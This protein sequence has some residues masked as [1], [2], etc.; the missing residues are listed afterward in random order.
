MRE[1]QTDTNRCE[2][3]QTDA[4]RCSQMQSDANRYSQIRSDATPILEDK[5][6]RQNTSTII[7]R[8]KF[9][10]INGS[11][12]RPFPLFFGNVS[13]R[14]WLGSCRG[15]IS[16]SSRR[17]AASLSGAP[18][19]S[20][21]SCVSVSGAF[22]VSGIDR[23]RRIKLVENVADHRVNAS[24][25]LLGQQDRSAETSRN[26]KEEEEGG[27]GGRGR[28]RKRREEV[29]GGWRRGEIRR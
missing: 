2:Q 23:F 5:W 10:F 13:E 27:G 22:G 4:N 9:V 19:V 18:A 25:G 11:N 29:E 12:L 14:F 24:Q 8:K 15:A 6:D 28:R 1:T 21:A 17:G 20:G 7:Y 3:M 26:L 16:W